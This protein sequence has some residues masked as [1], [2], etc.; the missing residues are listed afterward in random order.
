M[1]DEVYLF[2]CLQTLFN[3]K[4]NWLI[5]FKILVKNVMLIFYLIK[6]K[7]R[8]IMKEHFWRDDLFFVFFKC[9]DELFGHDVELAN[10]KTI[11]RDVKMLELTA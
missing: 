4:M 1:H 3:L 6:M 11:S 2:S 8:K 5:E 10:G 9:L 7:E